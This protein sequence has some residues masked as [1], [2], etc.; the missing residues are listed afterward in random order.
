M[1]GKKVVAT[2]T[3]KIVTVNDAT[4]NDEAVE[5]VNADG[6]RSLKEI[7]FSG[8]KFAFQ[9]GEGTGDNTSNSSRARFPRDA[10]N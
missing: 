4:S 6:S 8:K 2:A 7:R 3:A 5:N 10:N 1:Q 9:I